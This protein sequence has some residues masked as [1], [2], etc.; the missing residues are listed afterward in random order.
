MGP[1][2]LFDKSLLQSL[3]PDESA[4]LDHFFLTNITPIFYVET[5]ADLEKEVRSGRTPEQVVGNLAYKTPDS[6]SKPNV[7]HITLLIAELSGFGIDMRYGRPIVPGAQKVELEK[8]KGIIVRPSPEEEALA[9]WEREEFLDLE[10][11]LA[12]KWRQGLAEINNDKLYQE[13]REL[14]ERKGKPKTMAQAKEFA[15]ALLAERDPEALMREG[16]SLFGI[17]MELQNSAISRSDKAGRPALKELFPYFSHLLAVEHFFYI[18]VGSDLISK[19]RP[20]HR[21]DLA[22]LY[23][24]PFCMV[25]SSNDKLH[26]QMVPVF[27]TDQQTYIPG[28]D[29]KDDLARLDKYYSALPPEVL[30]RGMYNFAPAPPANNEFLITRLW[31][32]YMDWR[33]IKS[34]EQSGGQTKEQTQTINMLQDF[35]RIAIP[36]STD[37]ETD[38][39]DVIVVERHVLLR[40]GKWRRFPPEVEQKSNTSP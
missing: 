32:R 2:L 22:Y 11:T 5:L 18:A 10:R 21:V 23:Y 26:A 36:A 15:D 34:V 24:L 38:A 28:K 27:L 6:S 13:A 4:W 12:V 20:S 19:D 3:N 1:V 30:I 40:K 35:Q 31:D 37:F 17:P 8:K 29:L 33:G 39:S 9:R 7:H 16:M 14:V 25:S